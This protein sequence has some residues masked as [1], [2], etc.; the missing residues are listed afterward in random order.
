VLL[1]NAN[2]PK[3]LPG[4]P[5]FLDASV[6][7][8]P[9]EVPLVPVDRSMGDV[10]PFGNPHYLLDPING[11]KVA[12]LIRDRL[13]QLRIDQR[14]YFA[15]RYA[16]FARRLGEALVGPALAKQYDAEK[17]AQLYERGK[18]ASFLASQGDEGRLGGWL[19][20]LQ[21][22]FGTKGVD[23]HPIWAYFAHRFGLTITGHLEPKPGVPPTT[24]HLQEL[25]HLMRAEGVK[26]VLAAA[27]Y[28]PRHA[29]FVARETGAKVVRMAN[30]VGARPGTESYLDTID[31]NVRELSKALATG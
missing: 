3:I 7:I 28:D 4:R 21:R 17:L 14:P 22:G 29:E 24:K 11:L 6:V 2:N 13:G 8:T 18:L 26:V 30:Q 9:L 31:Y 12:A 19:G 16:E 27:Y 20:E 10:H 25:V 15:A 23:D 1:Q 5:G